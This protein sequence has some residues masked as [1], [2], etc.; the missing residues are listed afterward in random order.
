MKCGRE[1]EKE[2]ENSHPSSKT[3]TDDKRKRVKVFQFTLYF[4]TVIDFAGNLCDFVTEVA[5]PSLTISEVCQ[6]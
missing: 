6:N 1:D 4:L 3:Q 2:T 5:S